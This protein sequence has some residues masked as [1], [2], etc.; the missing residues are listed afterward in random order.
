MYFWMKSCHFTDIFLSKYQSIRDSIGWFSFFILGVMIMG[1][2]KCDVFFYS[3]IGYCPALKLMQE[4]N[5]HNGYYWVVWSEP[6]IAWT[7][8]QSIV[9]KIPRNQIELKQKN[10]ENYIDSIHYFQ[11]MS[12][13]GWLDVFCFIGWVDLS[14]LLG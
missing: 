8:K 6:K 5:G 2:I 13:L 9:H 4:F 7:K 10:D 1:G 3:I 12:L 14:Y 11:V